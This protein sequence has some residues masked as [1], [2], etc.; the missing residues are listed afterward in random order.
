MK[1][2]KLKKNI[3]RKIEKSTQEPVWDL[4]DQIYETLNTKVCNLISS[5]RAEVCG[6]LFDLFDFYI[7]NLLT[8]N[9][10]KAQ[11]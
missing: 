3:A 11:K 2:F 8:N 1:K 7:H 6:S 10:N 5:V 9:E 4:G